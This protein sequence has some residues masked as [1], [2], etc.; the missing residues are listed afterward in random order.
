VDKITGYDLN[1]FDFDYDLTFYVFFL[2]ADDKVYGRY[3]GRDAKSAED[4]LTLPGLRFAMQSALDA[5]RSAAKPKVA[6]TQ[7]KP[8]LAEQLPGAKKQN[9]CI[10]CHQVWE[11]RRA[12]AKSAGSFKRDDLWIYPLPENVGLS[13]DNNQGNKVRAVTADSPAAKAGLKPG[14]LVKSINGL[15]VNSFGDAQYALHRAPVKGSI[16][17]VWQQ[18]GKEMTANLEAAEGWR[19]TNVTWRPSMLDILPALS[20]YG[21]DLT[22]QEKKTLG[23]TEKR[24]AFV[25]DK[26]VGTDAAKMGVQKGD[27]II[28]INNEP[29]EMTVL[30]FLGYIRRNFLVGDKITLN[31]YRNGKRLDLP[32]QL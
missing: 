1:L 14:D 15:S 19:K 26:T 11:Y 23:L 28:G 30:E 16:P 20:V 5:H 25:Q 13:L 32:G 7:K 3:G 4:R 27:V 22:P 17:V 24:L 21:T 12:Q 6:A 9:G 29:L 18:S 2:N 10:H 31:I 8:L